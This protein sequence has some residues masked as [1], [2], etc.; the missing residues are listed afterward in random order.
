[1]APASHDVGQRRG[2][3][4]WIEKRLPLLEFIESQVVGSHELAARPR[5]FRRRFFETAL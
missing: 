5:G 1:M 3:V 2:F 4:S